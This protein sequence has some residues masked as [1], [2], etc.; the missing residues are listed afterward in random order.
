MVIDSRVILES[1]V[2]VDLWSVLFES[3]TNIVAYYML[4]LVF[5]DSIL[6]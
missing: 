4:Y 2:A 6:Q 3:L 1:R 5:T